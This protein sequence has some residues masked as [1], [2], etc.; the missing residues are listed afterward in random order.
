[1]E[2]NIKELTKL[3]S[4][5]RIFY[6][7]S[8]KTFYIKSF[9]KKIIYQTGSFFIKISPIPKS[10][11]R[12][13]KKIL[14]I[15]LHYRGDLLFCTP[16]FE[17]L[18]KIFTDS[19]IDVWC[20]SRASEVLVNNPN[21]NK[22]LIF[23]DIRTSEYE[24]KVKLSLKNKY[25]FL[26]ELRAKKYDLIIDCT[27]LYKTALFTLLSKPKYS[28]GRNIQGFGFCYNKYIEYDF[29]KNPGKLI[30]KYTNILKAGLSFDDNEWE[31]VAGDIPIKA[32]IYPNHQN[33]ITVENELRK[34]EYDFNKPL[35]CIHLTS[36]WEAKRWSLKNFE[37][38]I[39]LLIKDL[40]Y[41]VAIIGDSGDLKEYEQI[42]ASLRN[43]IYEK[44]LNNLF[45]H[46]TLI[47][48]TALIKRADVFIG[49]D[50]VPLHI[51]GA[52]DTPS[53]GLFGP[54]NPE[55]SNP[56]GEKHIV[57][58]KELFCSAGIN[59]QYCTRNAGKTCKTL[60]CMKLITVVEVVDCIIILLKNYRKSETKNYAGS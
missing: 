23:N 54:T 37:K 32:Y 22:I 55:F 53:I 39:D 24:G 18:K 20:K 28:I 10:E 11:I 36:G 59:D 60:D 38:L 14:I 12:F 41:E 33:S 27:G 13:I 57:L 56:S 6:L 51:A 25:K 29:F 34:R 9:L 48:T 31:S 17:I 46:L 45:F 40:N 47:N 16:I 21:I 4:K 15:S 44:K 3:V 2:I 50:S 19:D 26:K 43:N 7:Y 49:S 58:Y 35:I 30:D 5:I 52:V 42:K 8:R 1:M